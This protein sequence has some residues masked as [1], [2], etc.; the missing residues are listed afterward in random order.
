MSLLEGS[1]HLEGLSDNQRFSYL[2]GVRYKSNQYLLGTLDT[3]GDYSPSFSDIQ[4]LLR[5]RLSDELS[6]SFLGNFN[7]NHYQFEPEVQRTR[8]GTITD[9]REFT[10]FFDGRETN[11]F[12]TTTGALSLDFEPHPDFSLQLTSS[13]FQSDEREKL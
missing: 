13:F 7:D 6:L 11:R 9:V 2:V 3:Q 4:A 5:Y 10:V 1:V 8:F 12:T